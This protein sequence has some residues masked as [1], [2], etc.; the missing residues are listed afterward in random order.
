MAENYSGKNNIKINKIN[1]Y[2]G[3]NIGNPVRPTS[4]YRFSNGSTPNSSK[5]GILKEITKYSIND[6]EVI[7]ARLKDGRI[8]NIKNLES[9]KNI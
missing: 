9:A 1:S 2:L 8:F 7:V 5:G 6:L 3:L 4:F